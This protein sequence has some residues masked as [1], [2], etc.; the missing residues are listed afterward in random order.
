MLPLI[1]KQYSLQL[2][3]AVVAAAAAASACYSNQ[4]GILFANTLYIVCPVRN[5]VLRAN[6]SNFSEERLAMGGVS[7]LSLSLPNNFDHN[8]RVDQISWLING[9]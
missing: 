6:G 9:S 2:L 3:S 8:D 1:I 4:H 5:R 7:T